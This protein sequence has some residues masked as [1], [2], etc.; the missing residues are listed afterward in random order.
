MAEEG[1]V[2]GERVWFAD[3]RSPTRR[4]AVSSHPEAGVVVLSLWQG[5]RCTGSFRLPMADAPALVTALTADMTEVPPP[6]GPPTSGP[7]PS[8]SL[9][10]RIK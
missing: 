1:F 7:S 4:L 9:L 8:P 5:D 10:R 6:P 2:L 3:R